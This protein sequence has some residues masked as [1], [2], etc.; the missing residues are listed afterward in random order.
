MRI[1]QSGNIRNE[2]E[3]WELLKNTSARLAF[4]FVTLSLLAHFQTLKSHFLLP[5]TIPQSSTPVFIPVTSM[6]LI[7]TAI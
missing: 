5:Q 1:F 4:D 3:I 2:V 6:S 7:G